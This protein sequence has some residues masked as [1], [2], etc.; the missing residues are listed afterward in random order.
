MIHGKSL[1]PEPNYLK[2]GLK[3]SALEILETIA[4]HVP[5]SIL[6]YRLID[7]STHPVHLNRFRFR[8]RGRGV[9]SARVELVTIFWVT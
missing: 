3:C 9:Y 5:R 8:Q 1:S 7:V 2:A 6:H 4:C